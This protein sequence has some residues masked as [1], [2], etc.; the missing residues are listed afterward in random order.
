MKR[1]RNK[2][3]PDEDCATIMKS[4]LLGLRHIHRHDFVHRD[5]KPSNAVFGE[6]GVYESLKLVD[7]GLAVKQQTR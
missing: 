6:H 7:F 1:Y 3:I 4:I 2:H 5:L